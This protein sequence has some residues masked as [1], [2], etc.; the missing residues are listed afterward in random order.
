MAGAARR[1]SW[2]N[3]SWPGNSFGDG[4]GIAGNCN[5]TCLRDRGGP[6]A[7]PL[8][9]RPAARNVARCWP[10]RGDWPRRRGVD[11]FHERSTQA[12]DTFRRIDP[13]PQ[14]EL[15]VESASTPLPTPGN[16]IS[17]LEDESIPF[18][19]V[20]ATSN[21]DPLAYPAIGIAGIH[22]K[23]IVLRASGSTGASAKEA[24]GR[25]EPDRPGNGQGRKGVWKAQ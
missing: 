1:N 11:N 18:P 4:P 14:A 3:Q 23:A 5:G 19:G 12:R 17:L 20:N 15:F 6:G 25:P 24:T 21:A 7:D 16:C 10:D 9:R 13:D 2:P 8:E 22:A